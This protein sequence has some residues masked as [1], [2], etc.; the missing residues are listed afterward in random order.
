VLLLVISFIAG[1]LTILAP[2]VLPV[3]PIIIGG[4]IGG[5]DKQ[6]SRP[7]IIAAAL[8]GSIIIFT[9]V[10]KLSTVLINL[11]PKV[12][13]YGSGGLIVLLGVF[14]IFPNIW[15]EFLARTGLQAWSQRF[16]GEGSRSKNKYL[17][18]VLVG[19]ALGPVFSSCSPTYA[20]ILASVLPRNFASGL[21]FL[22]SYSLGLVLMLLIVSLASKRIISRYKWAIDTHSLFRRL[23]GVF[24]VLVGIAIIAGTDI[25]IETWIGNHT[26]FDEAKIEQQLLAKQ[27]QRKYVVATPPKGSPSSSDLSNTSLFDIKPQAEPEF[28]GLTNWINSKPLTLAQLKGKVVL[29]DFWTYSCINCLRTLPYVEKW[30][31]TYKDKG[32]VV[33]GL[34]A[35]EFAF[36]HVPANVQKAVKDHGLTY[37]VA[38]DN[39][40]QTWASFGNNSWPAD[41]LIDRE[42]KVRN[43]HS[44]EGDYDKTER[45]IQ[46]LLGDKGPLQTPASVVPITEDQTPETYFG[47]NRR[48]AYM[49]TPQL[50]NGNNNYV[51]ADSLAMGQWTIGG[52]WQVAGEMITS[53]GNDSTLTLHLH[54]KDVYAVAGTTDN[55]SK[56]MQVSE[57]GANYADDAPNG[58]ATIGGS[59]LYHILSLPASG[60]TT[61]KLT[62]PRGVSL[63]TFTFGS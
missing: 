42:G 20:F 45:A 36:E 18:P 41:Y 48:E 30:Y 27:G 58:A 4:S 57:P 59:R 61:V 55:S 43:V 9:L 50:E 54:A 16:L 40:M 7:Y 24:F 10:L 3:L 51:P 11:S 53:E 15:E 6:K 38:L 63:Y 1:I 49:G 25:R 29:V 32:F 46:I 37:P 60:E 14:S 62:V 35:P 21:I 44:G 17:G 8:A 13:T 2:C 23:L 22:I 39:D 34:S 52:N 5:H 12:L 19:V 33:V 28:V 26:P 31:E 47:T 56:V